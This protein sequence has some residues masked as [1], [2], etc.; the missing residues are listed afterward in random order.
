MQ[1]ADMRPSPESSLGARTIVH[2]ITPDEGAIALRRALGAAGHAR[3]LVSSID[4][5][6]LMD[7]VQGGPHVTARGDAAT[8]APPPTASAATLAAA[9]PRDDIERTLAELWT[10]LL[11]VES[12]GIRDNF[13]ELGGHSLI[14]VRL[15]AR[16]KKRYG[17]EL[18]LALLFEAPTIEQCAAV[19]RQSLGL[20][21]AVE[22]AAPLQG[23]PVLP[24]ST[25]QWTPLVRINAGEHGAPFFCVHGAGGNV[26]NFREL[27]RHLGTAQAFYGLQAQGVDGARPPL[28]SI[29]EM[30][31]LY[32][33]EIERVQPAGPI[34]LGGYSGGGVVALELARRLQAAGRWVPRVI[35]FDT[36][37]PG[38]EARRPSFS[39]RLARALSE[40]AEGLSR[41]ATRKLSRHLGELSVE[42]KLRF[43]ASQDA[44]LPLELRDE[45]LTRSFHESAER[46]RP[47]R[48][49]G[50]VTLFRAREVAEVYQHAGPRLG[51]DAYLPRLEIHEIP[52][53]HNSLVLEPN[54]QLLTAILRETLAAAQHTDEA[55]LSHNGQTAG[56]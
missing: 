8:V 37:C 22:A 39:T 5:F 28:A 46:Y 23:A 7:E 36:F 51:W 54:V 1:G 29:E 11:G 41:R 25:G 4:L 6:R 53:D 43:F 50:D 49:E 15:F 56:R 42:L 21:L 16:I 45:R 30:A 24:A 31:A 19:L 48:Y 20:T 40:G 55:T 34:L 35:L 9:A 47:I 12:V 26:L 32:Q 52:G 38:I 44:P 17:V 27:S 14:A 18:S 10:G 3:L 13:F 33:P 2:G